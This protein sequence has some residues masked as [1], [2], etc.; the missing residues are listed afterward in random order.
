MQWSELIELNRPDM[1][2]GVKCICRVI[3]YHLAEGK[4]PLGLPATLV[5][6]TAEADVKCAQTFTER[7]YCQLRRYLNGFSAPATGKRYGLH[8]T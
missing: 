7:L 1:L 5:A 6:R 4:K 2:T 3:D 8:H